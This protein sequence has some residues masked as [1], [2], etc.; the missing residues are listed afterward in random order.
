MSNCPIKNRDG[1]REKVWRTFKKYP[2]KTQKELAEKMNIT[3]TLFSRLLTEK[4]V[5]LREKKEKY[6]IVNKDV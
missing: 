3:Q 6:L 4:F 5:L 1:L 2:N